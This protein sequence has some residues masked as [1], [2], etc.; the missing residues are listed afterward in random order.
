MQD[1]AQFCGVIFGMRAKKRSGK[2]EF[3]LRAGAGFRVFKGS[4]CENRT[5]KSSGIQDINFYVT[6]WIDPGK[7][8]TNGSFVYSCV[9]FQF[10]NSNERRC[11]LSNLSI[12]L[13][14]ELRLYESFCD[15]LCWFLTFLTSFNHFCHRKELSSH[16]S[17]VFLKDYI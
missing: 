10:M 9:R 4:G 16:R 17:C 5:G 11:S 14:Y 6:A 7:T 13:K 8:G 3:Q 12:M 15:L 2:R 1:L